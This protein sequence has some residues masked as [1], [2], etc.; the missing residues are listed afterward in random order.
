MPLGRQ[1]AV[2]E[3]AGLL[4]FQPAMLLP[5][6]SATAAGF[7]GNP[8]R[9]LASLLAQPPRDTLAITAATASRRL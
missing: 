1:R 3:G 8:D 9:D 4:P 7:L 5:I 6:Y 2:L